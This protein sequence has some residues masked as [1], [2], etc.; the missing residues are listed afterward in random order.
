MA[1]PGCHQDAAN[2]DGNALTAGDDRNVD[3]MLTVPAGY[4][5]HTVHPGGREGTVAG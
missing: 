5:A 3:K 4:S 2:A 1:N